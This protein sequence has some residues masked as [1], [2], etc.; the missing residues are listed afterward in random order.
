[1][2]DSTVLVA[3]KTAHVRLALVDGLRPHVQIRALSEPDRVVAEVRAHRPTV[4]LIE[5][6]SRPKKAME[7][8]RQI[9]TD[10]GVAPQV[11]LLDTGGRIRRPKEMLQACDADGILQGA[12]H[13]AE[14]LQL[15][16]AM[17]AGEPVVIQ[18]QAPKHT[19]RRWLGR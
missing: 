8:C 3:M 6:G 18:G 15:L 17:N 12:A 1:M 10:A 4:V 19:L 7:R 2:K 9:K 5:V 11:G 16:Q 13:P 14:V